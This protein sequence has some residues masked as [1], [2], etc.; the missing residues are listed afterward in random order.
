MLTVIGSVFTL[1]HQS[2]DCTGGG[3]LTAVAGYLLLAAAA[4]P[5]SSVS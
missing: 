2:V 3:V 5:L 1:D 4:A